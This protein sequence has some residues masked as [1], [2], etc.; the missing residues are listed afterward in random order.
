METKK[1]YA[2]FCDAM[3]QKICEDEAQFLA[4]I[5]LGAMSWVLCEQNYLLHEELYYRRRHPGLRATLVVTHSRWRC[6]HRSRQ[7]A[8]T[9]LLLTAWNTIRHTPPFSLQEKR[10]YKFKSYS[11][12]P[13][14]FGI[15]KTFDSEHYTIASYT[16]N[17]IR[18]NLAINFIHVHTLKIFTHVRHMHCININCCPSTIVRQS[19]THHHYTAILNHRSVREE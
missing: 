16:E 19:T 1:I 7:R 9:S 15:T 10:G 17:L 3:Q 11:L 5:T 18:T 14:P 8:T 6:E 4:T 13:P 12:N 2:I